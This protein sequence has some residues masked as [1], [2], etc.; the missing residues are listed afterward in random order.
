MPGL[1]FLTMATAQIFYTS[2]LNISFTKEEKNIQVTNRGG[3]GKVK[4]RL[5]KGGLSQII[6]RFR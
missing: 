4:R 5:D 6:G 2:E 3:S 1:H